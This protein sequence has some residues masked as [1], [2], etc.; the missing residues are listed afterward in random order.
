MTM[1]DG[2]PRVFW[3]VVLMMMVKVD[4]WLPELAPSPGHEGFL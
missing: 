2:L 1:N 4:V 3:T